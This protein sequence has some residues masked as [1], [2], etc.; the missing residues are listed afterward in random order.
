GEVKVWD[1][2]TGKHLFDLQG[3]LAEARAVAFSPDGKWLASAGEEKAV[4]L[5][6]AQ[7]GQLRHTFQ[8]EAR[9]GEL[10][11]VQP[12]QPAAGDGFPGR[13]GEVM[14]GRGPARAP[15]PPGEPLRGDRRRL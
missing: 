1:V 2:A 5:W 11:G 3:H 8:G 6:D 9:G 7:T 4:R 10:R 15:H 13:L 14:G 12:R